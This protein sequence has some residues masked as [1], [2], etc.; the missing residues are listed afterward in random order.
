MIVTMMMFM[1]MA[2]RI[3]VVMPVAR[4]AMVRQ[5]PVGMAYAPVRQMAVVVMVLVHGKRR[6]RT[7]SEKALVF[8]ASCDRNRRSLAADMAVE[9]NH[10]VRRCHHDVQIMGDQQNA[11]A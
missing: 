9:A 5:R 10:L 2:A 8:R 6:R 11:A 7:V 4:M 1:S 3:I